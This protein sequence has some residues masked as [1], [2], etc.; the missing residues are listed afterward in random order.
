MN[1]SD[2]DDLIRQS[3]STPEFPSSFQ[4]EIWARIAVAEQASWS[5]R[6][7]RWS[8]S[9][10]GTLARPA[11]ALATVT[12]MLLLGAGIGRAFNAGADSTDPRAAYLATINPLV[13]YMDANPE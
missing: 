10:F 3:H 5:S 11:P 12:M 9:L 6:W 13:A 2:L 7:A 4:R 8:E 1:D